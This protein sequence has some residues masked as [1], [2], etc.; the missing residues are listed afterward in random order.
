MA[1][2]AI[3]ITVNA[4]EVQ[5]QQINSDVLAS[6]DGSKVTYAVGKLAPGKKYSFKAKLTSKVC[7]VTVEIFKKGTDKSYG[8][9]VF[10][11][12][13][14]AQDV[15]INFEVGSETEFELTLAYTDAGDVGVGSGFTVT[16]AVISL[17]FDFATLKETLKGNAETLAGTIGGYNYAAKQEDVE[18]ANALKKKAQ[19]VDET[20]DDYTKF[21]LYATKSTIQEEIEALAADAAAKEAAYQNEQAYNRVNA[22]IT[23]IK[24]KLGTAQTTLQTALN[25]TVAAYLL[26]AALNELDTEINQKITAATQA[27]YA[28]YQKGTALAD[29]TTNIDLV[30]TEKALNDIV[31][32]YVYDLEEG[33][34]DYDKDLA[35]LDTQAKKNIKAYN[36]L[37][38]IVETLQG[39]LDNIKPV[40]AIAS[41][42]PKTEAQGA[43]DAVSTDV[44]NA[45]NSAAQLTLDVTA[46]KTTAEGKINTLKGKVNTANAEY[47]ANKA[48]TEAIAVVQKAYNDA[49]TA[50]DAKVSK[51]GDYKAADYYAAYLKT[52]QDAIDKLTSDAGKA[53]KVDGTGSAQTYNAGLAAKTAPITDAI[54]A[55]QTN[56]IAAVGKYDDLQTAIAAYE[57]ELADARTAAQEIGPDVYT[58]ANYDYETQFDLIQKRIN[59]IKKAINT[60]KGKVGAE[61][62]TAMLAIDAD[63]DITNDIKTL[64]AKVQGDQN[65]YDANTLATGL[66]TLSDKIT[67]FKAKDESVLG[68]DAATF[69]GIETGI[70]AAYTAVKTASE[71]IDA[72]SETVDY[73]AKVGTSKDN[74]HGGGTYGSSVELFGN[75][76][77]GVKLYQDVEVEDGIYDIEVL[78]TSHN[79]WNGNNAS[80]TDANG[81]NPAPALQEDADDVAYVFGKGDNEVKTWITARRNSGMV[82]GEPM[83]YAIKGVKVSNGKLTIGLALAKKGQTEWHTIQIKSLKAT[84]ASLIQGWGA[85]IADLNDQQAALETFAA[86]IEAKVTANT[87]AQSD[88]AA[89]IGDNTATP[90]TGLWKSIDVFKTLYKIGTDDT[91]LG[92]TGKAGGAVAKEVGEI[93]TALEKLEGKNTAFDPTAVTEVDKKASVNTHKADNGWTTGLTQTGNFRDWTVAGIA[94]VEHWVSQGNNTET[95]TV[96]AQTVNNLPNGIYKV[97]L[98]ANAVDQAT[99]GTNGAAYVFANN[100]KENVPVTGN[101]N[102]N[103]YTLNNVIVSDGTLQLGMVKTAAGT[104]WHSIQIKSLT[105]HENDQLAA[106]TNTDEEALGYNL[107]YTALNNQLNALVEAAPGIKEKVANNAAVYKTVSTAMAGL[108]TYLDGK[109]KNETAVNLIIKADGSFSGSAK[110]SVYTTNDFVLYRTGL[111]KDYPTVRAELLADTVAMRNAIEAAFANET[112]ATEWVND[113][114]TVVTEDD[115]ATQ[116]VN[117]ASSTTYSITTLKGVIDA[118]RATAEAEQA[119]WYGYRQIRSSGSNDVGTK[120]K[121]ND[122]FFNNSF[123]AA[124]NDLATKAGEGAAAYYIGLVGNGT[125]I[126]GSYEDDLAAIRLAMFNS[127]KAR[128]AVADQS[129]YVAE[130]KALKAKIDAV[131]AAAAANLAKYNEQK[132]GKK[133]DG[134]Y[135]YVETQNLWNSTYTEIAA[136][137]QSSKAQDWLDE[138]DSIQVVLTAA[139]EAVEANYKVGES[140]AKAQDFAAIQAAINDVKARQSESYNE[141]IAAD[142]KAAHEKFMVNI[143]NATKAYQKAVQE[144]AEFSSTNEEVKAAIDALAADLDDAI[145]FAPTAIAALTQLENNAYTETVSPTVFDVDQYNTSAVE[146]EQQIIGKLN[147]FKAGVK[148]ALEDYWNPT[149]VELNGKVTAAETAIA[150]YSDAAKTDAFKDVKDLIDKADTGVDKLKLSEIEDAIAALENIDAMLAADK[151]A[152]AVKDI[153]AATTAANKAYTDT[154]AYIEGK[155]IAD[156]VN[157]VKATELQNLETANTAAVEALKKDKTFDNHDDIM[158]ALNNVVTVANTAKTNVDNAIT[159][160]VANTKAYNDIIAVLNPLKEKLA[161]AKAAVAPYKYETSFGTDEEV[162]AG[163]ENLTEQA[164]AQGVAAVGAFKDNMLVLLGDESTS[165]DGTLTTAFNTEKTGLAADITELKNQFNAYVAAKGLDET[166]SA[167]KKDI[168]DLEAALNAAEIKDLDKPTD[169]IQYDEILAATEAL[170]K[171]QND[172]ADKQTELLAANGNAANAAVLADFQGQ[173][174]DL[175]AAA[176][177]EGYDEWVGQQEYANGKTY[178]EAIELLSTKIADL[179][180]AIE[181][182]ENISFYQEQYQN[183]ITQIEALLNPIVTA[184]G[185]LDA[186][187]KANDAAYERLTGEINDLQKKI[188][189]AKEKVGDY[190]YA[191][192]INTQFFDII[193]EYNVDNELI[194]GAQYQLNYYAK[195]IEEKNETK[196]LDKNY[197]DDAKWDLGILVKAAVKRYLDNSANAE[198]NA[199]CDNLQTLLTNAI[200]VKKKTQTYSSALW[201]RLITEKGA[202]SLE[203]FYLLRDIYSS[204]QSYEGAFDE[205]VT[206]TSEEVIVLGQNLGTYYYTLDEDAK[207]WKDTGSTSDV[208]FEAQMVEVNRIKELIADLSDAVDN[209]GLLGDANVDGKVNVLD[210][211]KVVNMILDPTQQPEE[212]TNLFANTDVNQNEIIEVGDLTAIVNYI[213]TGDWQ[214]YAAAARSMNAEGE[215]IAMNVSPMEQGKQRIAVSLANVSDYTAF[216]M[217]MVLPEGMTFVGASLTNRA[218]ESHKLYSRAQLDGSIRVLASSIKG[219]TFSGSE[220]AVLYIDVEGAGSV[221]LVNILFSDVNAQTHLFTIGGDA[222]GI[223]NVSTLDSLKQ[224]VY[225]FGGRLVKGL[226]KGMNIIRR[227]DGSTDKV[228]VK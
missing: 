150:G 14:A 77:V 108:K 24:G 131:Q 224:Q 19:D 11:A 6:T 16:D 35:N 3:P 122:T 31:N 155:T 135:G 47:N 149:K 85:K 39:N 9:Q 41:L 212:E 10:D 199:Q 221:E 153:T 154:K 104:N 23:A 109:L 105:F 200:D 20:Y 127:L 111:D 132:D 80:Y 214:G 124:R 166:A 21:K 96:F 213:L 34:L 97:E 86:D 58:D 211:Q 129:G 64:L 137:D 71:A 119:N 186:K 143:E 117:E 78:A 175:A 144:R 115:P 227:N 123:T 180:A 184:M 219:E 13:S 59:D 138:L 170:I 226:K 101:E 46:K 98:Y 76:S 18:A 208:D 191:A 181:A 216:Q 65:E 215:S 116:D 168:D 100:V 118:I 29:E 110:Q 183:E 74:W 228:I 209:L 1:L 189:D 33:D 17:D 141:F 103:S 4:A 190:E 205:P 161:E 210:Y 68:A 113:A 217:D 87:K 102:A 187:C 178:A 185:A 188:N 28:S 160:D 27:S 114:I 63:A 8:K 2:G 56:A 192:E 12:K 94:S 51:D 139:T 147:T 159:A 148:E 156:D 52:Q 197:E 26:D 55:Y 62:W 38:A 169:G 30:P 194:D 48:T 195:E 157:N 179:K 163:Y 201:N 70:N 7:G 37:C 22:A 54:S 198:L 95:G 92:N 165:I 82:E 173:L 196:S 60:A 222:T 45:K 66:T 107:Q 83:T 121:V 43:I 162:V 206:T 61:H 99:N 158:D 152:A 167:F 130:L 218:G 128:T 75:T 32:N 81:D 42:F 207:I 174:N 90:K 120:Q 182:E 225:D 25:G 36:D 79:A 67:A 136:T 164:K 89:S 223:N 5:Q 151:D 134:K 126:T 146:L 176:S 40:E 93:E 44:E 73:T 125:D 91:T 203:I 171:L 204:H 53:Y 72:Q 84:T 49:K 145:Y 133:A 177:L 69:Q 15:E 202:I 106:Y 112:L 57:K 142:N 220:G 50:V 172:I 88:L 193:E 140:V